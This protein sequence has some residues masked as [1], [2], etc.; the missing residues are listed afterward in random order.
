[1]SAIRI[2]L[3][4]DLALPRAALRRL[5]EAEPEFLVVA[6]ADQ[7]EILW[8]QM[9]STPPDVVVVMS[10][11]ARAGFGTAL[12]KS[13]RQQYPAVRVVVVSPHDEPSFVRLL[14]SAGASGYVC[15]QSPPAELFQAI[16]E[17]AQGR[18]YVDAHVAARV[19]PEFVGSLTTPS[20]TWPNPPSFLSKRETE[21]LKLLAHGY[22]NQQVAD[23]LALSVKTAESYRARLSRK[24]GVKTRSELFRLA[25]EIGMIDP[26]Q[27][28]D[29]EP[30]A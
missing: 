4:A 14:L 22:T 9:R 3:A 5:L 13:L 6:E 1:M 24:L 17:V 26:D 15:N 16:R 30:T 25:Y 18:R 29:D 20:P 19:G 23:M 21:V 27:L 10:V 7:P 11:S 28:P 12:I 8:E 2:L